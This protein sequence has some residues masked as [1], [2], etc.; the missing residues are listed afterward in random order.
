MKYYFG[1]FC[2]RFTGLILLASICSCGGGTS[3]SGL[4][5][6]KGLIDDTSNNALANV[7]VTIET[8]G[9]R[10][11]TDESGRFSLQSSASGPEVPFLIESHDFVSRF[12]LKE[13][14]DDS[15]HISVN[16]TVDTETDI[17]TVDQ[18]DVRAGFVGLCD[19]YFENNETIRQANHVPEGTICTLKV[20]VFGDGQPLPHV[21]VAVQYNS[22]E[23]STPWETLVTS[24]TGVGVRAGV[25]QLNFPFIDS[26]AYC[27][28]RVV[29]PF[30][31]TNRNL[32][33]YPIDTFSEQEIFHVH[34]PRE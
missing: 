10:T 3:G 24:Y 15:A 28:Y 13:I 1:R 30:G 29:A 17:A 16:I 32:I 27:R 26:T 18:I 14:P 6:Y 34:S 9:D 19:D 8:T 25:V 33:Y 23:A 31:A 20:R 5:T 21:P 2:L 22:C 4:K 12:V 11:V 7:D